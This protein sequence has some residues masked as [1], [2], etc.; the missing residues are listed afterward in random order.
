[1]L[2]PK[3]TATAITATMPHSIR[4]TAFQLGYVCRYSLAYDHESGHLASS[5]RRERVAM[6]PRE[7]RMS[8]T[9]L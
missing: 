8:G 4:Q 3:M 5:R 1:L 7:D 6:L 2:T 9:T